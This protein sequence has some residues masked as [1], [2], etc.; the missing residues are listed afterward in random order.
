MK[1]AVLLW[2]KARITVTSDFNCPWCWVGKR[3]LDKAIAATPDVDFEV[4][5]RPYFLDPY[6][7]LEGK[8]KVKH[9]EAKYGRTIKDKWDRLMGRLNKHGVEVKL[10][11]GSV[12]AHTRDAHR[13]SHYVRT[14]HG[15]AKQHELQEVLF[16]MNHTEG[17]NIS[18]IPEL[19]QAAAEVG[20]QDTELK[21]YLESDR[22]LDLFVDLNERSAAAGVDG[23]PHFDVEGDKVTGALEPAEFEE[24]FKRLKKE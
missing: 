17:R 22:D 11:E 15:S 23:V 18:A 24:M 21:E 2:T 7:P 19:L 5:W 20:V 14:A 16:R 12:L 10:I 8:D 6:L 1:R 9:Y 4:T 3:A 13:L